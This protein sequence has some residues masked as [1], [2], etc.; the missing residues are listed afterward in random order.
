[1]N[2]LPAFASLQQQAARPMA[3]SELETMGK[4]AAES[5]SAGLHSSIHDA[6]VTTV[7]CAQL[8]PEQVKRVVEFANQAAFLAAHKAEGK[9]HKYVDFGEAGPANPGEVLQELNSGGG[10]TVFDSGSN[11][12]Q[13]EPTSAVSSITDR[14]M[15]DGLFPKTASAGYEE[16]EPLQDSMDLYQKLAGLADR[17]GSSIN[18]LERVCDETHEAL[19]EQV[20]QA[21]LSGYSLADVVSIWEQ[22]DPSGEYVKVAFAAMLEPLLESG[23]F[24]LPDQVTESLLKQ[25][26]V[27]TPDPSTPIVTYFKE[28]CEVVDKL[29]EERGNYAQ[30]VEGAA[31]LQAFLRKEAS[32]GGALHKAVDIVRKGGEHAQ[33]GGEAAGKWLLGDGK[34]A[35]RI[36]TA[37]R[38]ATY[39]APAAVAHETYRRTLGA[40]PTFQ[41]AK[42]HVLTAVPGTQEYYQKD[43][44]NQAA[45]PY[46]YMG[47]Y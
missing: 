47:N 46:S 5:W 6:V 42:H 14:E 18:S 38:Y 10:G 37:A 21:T 43:M 24:L 2:D 44:E 7:K 8:S 25:A 23:V 4:Q 36:G 26:Q 13:I 9:N 30:Y 32:S 31:T 11:P 3:G 16:S 28:Y 17:S 27:G 29:A 33:K 40:S 34:G 39:A 1:M 20:K 35:K 22:V 45:N 41:K 12:Y 19:F 15:L